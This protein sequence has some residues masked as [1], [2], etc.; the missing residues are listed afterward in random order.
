MDI[1]LIYLLPC[2]IIMQDI[3]DRMK[4]RESLEKKRKE[5]LKM[6]RQGKLQKE[7]A[8]IYGMSVR[9]VQEVLKMCISFGYISEKEYNAC[10]RLHSGAINFKRGNK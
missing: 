10:K 8:E 7:I 4:R 3:E 9:G 6:Y 2:M 5:I 1:K